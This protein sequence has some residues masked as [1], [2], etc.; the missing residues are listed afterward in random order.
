M[1]FVGLSP[2]KSPNR[3]RVQRR[4]DNVDGNPYVTRTE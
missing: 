3:Q 1:T 4:H 2:E